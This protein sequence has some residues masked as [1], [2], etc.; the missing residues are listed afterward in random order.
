[1][2]SKEATMWDLG[3]GLIGTDAEMDV[4]CIRSHHQVKE[5]V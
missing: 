4:L 2:D 1:M 3:A 5:G